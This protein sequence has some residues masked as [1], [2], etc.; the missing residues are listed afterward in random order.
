MHRSAAELAL[1]PLKGP[2]GQAKPENPYTLHA[3]LQQTMNDLVGI[4]RRADEITTALDRLAGLKARAQKLSVEGHRQFNPG[5]HL[6]L[7]LQN[8]LVVSECIA[9][10]A[11]QRE[12]SRGGHTRDDFPGMSDAWRVINLVCSLAPPTVPGGPDGDVTVV[13]TGTTTNANS[14]PAN[15]N[16]NDDNTQ[17]PTV[18]GYTRQPSAVP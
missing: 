7:D 15:G 6:A 16:G 8:M 12:E 13:L 4:I 2:Q 1:Q 17:S 11:L 18:T 3:D 5:W 9:R 14:V 10:A